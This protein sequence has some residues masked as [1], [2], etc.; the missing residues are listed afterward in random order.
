M[1]YSTNIDPKKR[2]EQEQKRENKASESRKEWRKKQGKIE[3][4]PMYKPK[5]KQRLKGD[6]AYEKKIHK[7]PRPSIQQCK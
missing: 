6:S 1:F 5:P 3:P 4:A 2:E 7:Q